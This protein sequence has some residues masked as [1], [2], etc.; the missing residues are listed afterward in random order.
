VVL[1]SNDLQ[2]YLLSQGIKAKVMRLEAPTPTV[3][4]A[5]TAVGVEPDQIVKSLLFLVDDT[6]VLAIAN[7]LQDVDRRAV[8]RY[9]DVGRKRVKLAGSQD[10]LAITGYKAGAVPPL[11]WKTKVQAFIDPGVLQHEVVYAGGGDT[12]TLVEISPRDIMRH[13]G[14]IE[15]DLFLAEV[16]N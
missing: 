8:A 16:D 5:A 7:G 6:P 4:A 12:N 15:Y 2:Q 11:G 10:V 1:D 3:T 9:F 13:S 14:A